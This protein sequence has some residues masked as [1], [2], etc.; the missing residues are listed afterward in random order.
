MSNL[1]LHAIVFH[2]PYFTSEK[3]ALK[4]AHHMF[5]DEK[6]KTFVRETGTSFRVR[7]RPKTNFINTSYIT[8]IINPGISLIFGKL[9]I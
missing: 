7:I 1:I 2:K 9:K 5:P 8:K 6:T 4:K 3:E